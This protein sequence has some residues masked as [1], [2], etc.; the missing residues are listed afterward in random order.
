MVV[1]CMGR[2]VGRG[3]PFHRA[4][5]LASTKVGSCPHSKR[6]VGFCPFFLKTPSAALFRGTTAKSRLWAF[7]WYLP[8]PNWTPY[9]GV[10]PTQRL[11]TRSGGWC[12]TWGGTPL[13]RLALPVLG[14]G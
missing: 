1:L 3:F 2:E 10:M 12:N 11:T 6:P 14:G 7:Q 8:C 13:G 4:L 5:P 9:E